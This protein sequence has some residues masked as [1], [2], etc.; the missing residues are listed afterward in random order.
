MAHWYLT[1]VVFEPLISCMR[2]GRL[3][4]KNRQIR[5]VFSASKIFNTPILPISQNTWQFHPKYRYKYYY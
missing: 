3:I 4:P 5:K 1:L 2:S